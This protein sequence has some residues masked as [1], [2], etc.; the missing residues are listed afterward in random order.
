[1]SKRK[2]RS[3]GFPCLYGNWC[4]PGCSGPD[5]PIDNVDRCCKRH[6]ECYVKHG[7]FSCHCDQELVRC[8]RNKVNN[9][10]EKGRMAGIISNFFSR[11]GCFPSNP[12]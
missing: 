3:V 10:T 11:T 1:M 7:Y 5:A 8:L 6:D 12:R 4:G 2:R 9:T